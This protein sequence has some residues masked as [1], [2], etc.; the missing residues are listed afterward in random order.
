MKYSEKIDQLMEE[1]QRL[2]NAIEDAYSLA[3]RLT[4]NHTIDQCSDSLEK[5][6]FNL[7]VQYEKILLLGSNRCGVTT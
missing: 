1:N 4:P 2:K 3:Y 5:Q 7:A 6:I